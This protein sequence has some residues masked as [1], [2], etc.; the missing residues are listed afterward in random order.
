[1]KRGG[2]LFVVS[3]LSLVL[4]L[5][6]SI[7]IVSPNV[8]AVP[9]DNATTADEQTDNNSDNENTDGN[10]STDGEEGN[11]DEET[12]EAGAHGFGW[13]LCPGQNLI[14]DIFGFF[15]RFIADSLEWTLLADSADSIQTIWQD[16]LNIAN[17][18][19][20]IAFLVMIYSMATSTGL[21]NYDIKK[22]LPRLIIIAIAVNL[23][24]YLCAALVDLS[25]IAGKGIYDL[26][27]SRMTGEG[28]NNLDVN[29]VTSIL[30]AVAAAVA[31]VFLGGAALIGLLIIII[32][33]TFR[34]VAL[35]LLVIVSPIAL[36]LYMLPNTEKWGKKWLSYFT[37]MLLVY[38]MFMAVWGASQLVSNILSN[39]EGQTSLV[40]FVV[41]ILSAI[42]PAL[43]IIPLFRASGGILGSVTKSLQGSSAAKKGSTA[44]T[45][46]VQR[47]RPVSGGRRIIS[48]AALTAQN[49]FGDTPVIGRALRGPAANRLVNANQNYIAEQDK[50]AMDSASNWVKGLTGGQL[51]SLAT[52]GKYKTANGHE[53]GV[54]DTHKLRAA[55]AASKDSF[56]AGDWGKS[57]E[58]VNSRANALAAAGRANEAA[59]LRNTFKDTALAS[60]NMVIT[61]GALGDWA[62]NGWKNNQFAARY[63]QGA[64]KFASR[65]SEDKI[66]SMAP[67]ATS[68][69]SRAMSS[70]LN[71]T[72]DSSND[73]TAKERSEMRSDYLAG[74]ATAQD[75][76]AR[77]MDKEKI[78]VKMNE[79]AKNSWRSFETMPQATARTKDQQEIADKYNLDDIISNYNQK[80]ADYRKA[81]R[82]YRLTG[83]EAALR[84][85]GYDV[86]R[87]AAPASELIL[88]SATNSQV[89]QDLA[90]MSSGDRGN[91]DYLSRLTGNDVPKPITQW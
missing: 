8:R 9:D 82:S 55:I 47:S 77:A 79:G 60:K 63:G 28:L 4:L 78:A 46:A 51:S 88:S 66:G 58:W 48:G 6:T 15:L 26:L 75:K 52:T 27:T 32:A 74:L 37:S 12:C 73:L 29:L 17:V 71:A 57:M 49:A 34:Q 1:M 67:A 90:D 76:S 59:Q 84:Q 54:T 33:I 20:V 44:V 65:L 14:T 36:A 86:I 22:I 13:V 16:F 3:I 21:S 40:P 30:G 5:V 23:S 70:G 89:R 25:N 24:L 80:L 62:D 10:E 68:E 42:A 56:D 39:Q 38:P 85:A 18:V 69:L 64:S 91:L 83:D 41:N 2:R 50:K 11:A 45:S 61:G 19:F 81:A 35:M 43:A 53:V 72:R 31:V 7:G 87:A